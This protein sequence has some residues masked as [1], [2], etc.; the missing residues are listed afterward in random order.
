MKRFL[1]LLFYA[2]LI[3]LASGCRTQPAGLPHANTWRG[4]HVIIGNDKELSALEKQ[5]PKLAQDGANV[6]VIEISYSFD[7]KS[8]PELRT[9]NFVTRARAREFT[10]SARKL[11]LEVI[12]EFNCLG[13]QSWSSNTAP[14]LTRYPQFDETPGQFPDNQGI[15]CRSWCPQAPG[16]NKIIFALIDEEADAFQARAF[17]VGMDEVFLIGSEHCPRC[18]GEDPAELFAKA[19]HDLHDHIVGERKMEMLMWGDRLLNSKAMGYGRYDAAMNGT[20]RAVDLIPKDIIICDW[21]YRPWPTFPSVPFLLEKGFRVWPSGFQPLEST[22]KFS[23]FSLEQR[24]KNPRV[25][26]YLCTTWGR[27]KTVDITEWPPITEILLEW[28]HPK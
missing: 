26:G 14:L 15:Y 5:L 3:A 4:V 10:S 18:H 24:K 12:P 11:G 21:H 8:H 17:H 27:A 28:N 16:L 9:A 6:L 23:E 22:K 7:F 20:E 13:H 25:I 19:V 2:G 1:V